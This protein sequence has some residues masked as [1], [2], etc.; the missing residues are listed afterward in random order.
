MKKQLFLFSDACPTDWLENGQ[1]SRWHT[2][3]NA[4]FSP[5]EDVSQKLIDG[6]THE[7]LLPQDP[8]YLRIIKQISD[9]LPKHALRAWKRTEERYRLAF[10][11]SFISAFR[12]E[13]FL[14]N[15][16]SFQ[17]GAL[18]SSKEA[19][20]AAFNS[21]LGGPE[22]RGIGFSEHVD[23]KGRRQFTHEYVDFD[24]FHRL[25]APDNQMLVLLLLTWWIAGQLA[26]YESRE[27]GHELIM[28]VISDVL[29]GDHRDIEDSRGHKILHKLLTVP[30][31]DPPPFV[32]TRS[33]AKDRCAGD[34]LVD[35][36]AGWLNEAI[37]DPQNEFGQLARQLISLGGI[38]GWNV[39]VPSEE[40]LRAEKAAVRL[41]LATPPARS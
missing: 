28:I 26:F 12:R 36:L 29:S 2:A 41:G 39:L 14:I 25:Q 13:P 15:V 10:C 37:V 3:V 18:R 20:L 30:Y 33:K 1:E 34:L 9:G 4:L 40:R 22:G 8:K 32:V 11:R 35:N 16:C 24:G 19:V 17:E 7:E 5:D 6:Q 38:D 27:I 23:A 31:D 21:R